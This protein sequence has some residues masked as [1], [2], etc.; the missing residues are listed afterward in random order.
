[1]TEDGLPLTA[2]ASEKAPAPPS[3]EGGPES[4]PGAQV[5]AGPWDLEAEASGSL[6]VDGVALTPAEAL[7]SLPLDAEED[8]EE[9]FTLELDEIG[10]P[11]VP[12][13][14]EGS[15]PEDLALA[16][17]SVCF[18]LNRPVTVGELSGILG[19]PSQ[20]VDR[21][22]E[23]LAG[24]LRGRGLMLQ[25][26]RDQVQLVTRPETAWAVQRAL[27]PERP[28]RLS[29]PALETLAIIAY[30]QPVTR[31][32]IESIRG[33]NCE[34]VL[35]SLERRGLIAEIGRAGTPGQPRLF[36]TTLRFLQLVGLERVDQLPPLPGGVELPDQQE[37]AWS[38]A[39][40]DPAIGDPGDVADPSV[41]DPG[42]LGDA[43]RDDLA[44]VTDPPGDDAA[45]LADPPDGDLAK[46]GA[47]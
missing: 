10:R 39:L 28:A 40:A 45:T 31:A 43:S 33:V 22:A 19:Q 47:S 30:R 1:M 9:G 5:R 7:A 29:R 20:R 3:G 44:R 34:A 35:E 6:D 24:Q 32:L 2:P 4:R 21:A 15:E 16:L 37:R 42:D 25:R 38:A 26:H 12:A 41:G 46:P 23:S 13:W 8:G 36:G 11:R 14:V 27:N 18:V 17:E